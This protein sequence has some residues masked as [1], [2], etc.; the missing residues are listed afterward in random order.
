[1]TMCS[2]PFQVSAQCEWHSLGTWRAIPP[3]PLVL[4]D[5]SAALW[6]RVPKN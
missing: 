6:F 5:A 4:Y 1:M 3:A 2:A